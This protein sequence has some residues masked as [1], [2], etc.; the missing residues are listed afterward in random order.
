[1]TVAT[2]LARIRRFIGLSQKEMGKRVGVSG[3]TWQNYE[4]ENA[5]PNA[6]VLA[7]LSGEGFDI[8]WV[9]TG[10]G[11]MRASQ[12]GQTERDRAAPDPGA[13][14]MAGFAELAPL[15]LDRERLVSSGKHVL[16]PRYTVRAAARDDGR[17]IAVEDVAL[18]DTL[19]FHR[20]FIAHVLKADPAALIAV[21]APDDTMQ[22]TFAAGD[23]LL[24]DGSAPRMRGSGIYVF[25]GENALIVKRL[26]VKLDG[27]ITVSSDN[28]D[29]YPPEE[30]ERSALD[31][32]KIIGR[33]IW[34]GGRL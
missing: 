21:E 25:A 31:K 13:R 14:K 17:T 8:N 19:T 24:A 26:Q 10:E 18:L 15:E 16:V 5:A 3:T 32:V 29:L 12:A 7:R 20:D 11:Q 22:P 28:A 1:M 33:V 23:I 27:S 4:L 6:H 30:I 34:R 2:R 9:L